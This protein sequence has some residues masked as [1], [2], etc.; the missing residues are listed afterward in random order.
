MARVRRIPLKRAHLPAVAR[1]PGVVRPQAEQL[2]TRRSEEAVG[3][4]V[5]VRLGLGL[6]AGAARA[7]P[8]RR[9]TSPSQSGPVAQDLGDGGR[10]ARL[11]VA[12][13]A[14]RG[15]RA[16]RSP[17]RGP[18][19]GWA[20]P[21]GARRARA[22]PRRPAPPRRPRATKKPHWMPTST[23]GAVVAGPVEHAP[24]QQHHRP[25][26]GQ[27]DHEPVAARQ[28]EAL[29]LHAR[30][31]Q[32]QHAGGD[33]QDRRLDEREDPERAQALGDEVAVGAA[34]RPCCWYQG[35]A[36]ESTSTT[37]AIPAM[38]CSGGSSRRRFWRLGTTS[39]LS[40][41]RDVLHRRRRRLR[42]GSSRSIE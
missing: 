34:G 31:D 15:A 1:R 19:P 18:R 17:S 25:A 30:P 5:G 20:A 23:P 41:D 2:R 14:R 11:A 7:G 16:R 42:P 13:R 21:G 26:A 8:G 9:A 40:G 27:R 35:S 6:A 29:A 22:R 4:L 39:S 36:I 12:R 10:V 38:R 3:R 28:V 32:E 24:D 37:A 33:E